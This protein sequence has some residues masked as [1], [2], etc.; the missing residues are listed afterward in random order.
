M[1][2]SSLLLGEFCTRFI[3]AEREKKKAKEA[4]KAKT[5]TETETETENTVAAGGIFQF[6]G[7]M[8]S[9]GEGEMQLGEMGLPRDTQKQPQGGGRGLI[10]CYRNGAHCESSSWGV[11]WR[12]RPGW[13][14]WVWGAMS[15]SQTY[16][17]YC[18][19]NIYCGYRCVLFS[20]KSQFIFQRLTREC[21]FDM[22]FSPCVPSS[23][24]LLFLP[25][26]VSLPLSPLVLPLF[27]SLFLPSLF[28]PLFSP[29]STHSFFVHCFP[30][31]LFAG[32]AALGREPAKKSRSPVA[33][34]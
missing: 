15:F 2:G 26:L 7:E 4:K 11:V 32:T 16:H 19:F 22:Y 33:I 10:G 29:C 13:H 25:P 21:S 24:S 3:Q 34:T 27:L 5:E 30:F 17:R 23:S 20:Y 28:P 12:R 18:I 14:V 1:W 6:Q 8:Q 9:E 31:T